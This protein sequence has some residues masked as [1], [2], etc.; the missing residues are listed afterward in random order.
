[1]LNFRPMSMTATSAS[2]FRMTDERL[3]IELPK[4]LIRSDN[5]INWRIDRLGNDH[6]EAWVAFHIFIQFFEKC[7]RRICF[8][9]PIND[10]PV[11][12]ILSVCS[13][14]ILTFLA[15]SSSRFFVSHFPVLHFHVLHFC[16]TFSSLASF[17][18]L[19]FCTAF[20]IP[21][22]LVSLCRIFMSRI[23]SPPDTAAYRSKN[24]PNRQFVPTPVS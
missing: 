18:A 9:V 13:L 5:R 15:F 24:R 3:G 11:Y 23:F 21:A 17:P 1:M 16:A 6:I 8:I 7:V 12:A 20:S 19:Q 10:D 2:L 22:F 14:S 4:D